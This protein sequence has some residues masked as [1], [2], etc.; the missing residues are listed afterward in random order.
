ML[1][2]MDAE[3]SLRERKKR[4]TRQRIADVA[5]HLFL[6]RGFDTVTVAEIAAAADVSR[7]TVFNY[8]PRKEDMFFDRHEEAVALFTGAVRDRRPG[9]SIPAALRRLVLDLADREH[10]LSGLRDGVQPFLR[11]VQQSPTLQAAARENREDLERKVAD[12]IAQATGAEPG[13]PL[14]LLVA[15]TAM[16]AHHAGYRFATGRILAGESAADI[17][18]RHHALVNTAFDLLEN[19]AGDYGAV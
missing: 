16:A 15:A 19:G 7:V 8:F 3:V 14:P 17:R 4:E 2:F 5:T 11:T 9:E 6:T 12:A 13:D 10:P 1:F 18:P